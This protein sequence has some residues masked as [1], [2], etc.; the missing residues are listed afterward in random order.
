[1]KKIYLQ[2]RKLIRSKP[3]IKVKKTKLGLEIIRTIYDEFGKVLSKQ[4]EAIKK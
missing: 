2:K 3:S 4:V 1:M